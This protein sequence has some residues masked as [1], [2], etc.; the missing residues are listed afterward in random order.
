MFVVEEKRTV[1]LFPEHIHRKSTKTFIL[2]NHIKLKAISYM[3]STKSLKIFTITKMEI[4]VLRI[5]KIPE[6]IATKSF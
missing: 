2:L 5:Y 3:K 1:T 6:K 4:S